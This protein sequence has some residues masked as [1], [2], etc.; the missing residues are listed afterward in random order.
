MI[1]CTML[2]FYVAESERYSWI[3]DRCIFLQFALCDI[4]VLGLL[5]VMKQIKQ[6]QPVLDMKKVISMKH[7]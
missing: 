4:D 6:A 1:Y 5:D 7:I 2:F 3:D